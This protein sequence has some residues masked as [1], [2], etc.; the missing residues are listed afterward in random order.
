MTAVAA[1]APRRSRREARRRSASGSNEW[2][3][4]VENRLFTSSTDG[5]PARRAASMRRHVVTAVPLVD[6]VRS[7]ARD[8]PLH[9]HVLGEVHGRG[10]QLQRH[11]R[12]RA[13]HGTRHAPSGPARCGRD[14]VHPHRRARARGRP[15][16]STRCGSPRR[17]R[18]ACGDGRGFSRQDVSTAISSVTVSGTSCIVTDAIASSRC[19][20]TCSDEGRHPLGVGRRVGQDAGRPGA[21]LARDDRNPERQRL[22]HRRGYAVGDRRAQVQRRTPR[23]PSGTRRDRGRPRSRSDRATPWRRIASC[24]AGHTPSS[25]WPVPPTMTRPVSGRCL[26]TSAMPSISVTG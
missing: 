26:I 18:R 13:A 17:R 14:A 24:T 11:T 20:R 4:P 12:Q 9:L 6:Q 2:Y 19:A 22:Q 23:A 1:R 5:I 16:P 21:V 15:P 3:A 10:R 7:E 8:L 25:A